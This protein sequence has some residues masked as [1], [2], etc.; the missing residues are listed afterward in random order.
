MIPAYGNHMVN[1]G[2]RHPRPRLTKLNVRLPAGILG[3]PPAMLLPAI[4]HTRRIVA[5]KAGRP[6]TARN[7]NH[8]M[9]QCAGRAAVA[10]FL[11]DLP[12]SL[13]R[14]PFR[15]GCA[16]PPR[17]RRPVEGYRVRAS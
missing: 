7:E 14:R 12:A 16:L 1:K 9:D 2:L 17:F 11:F 13:V 15:T 10:R 4:N 8:Q 3:V 6:D 5:T